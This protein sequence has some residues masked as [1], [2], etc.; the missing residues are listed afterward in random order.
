MAKGS[1]TKVVDESLGMR[2]I[3]AVCTKVRGIPFR[4]WLNVYCVVLAFVT[5]SLHQVFGVR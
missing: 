3:E 4:E 2:R 5:Y 1:V